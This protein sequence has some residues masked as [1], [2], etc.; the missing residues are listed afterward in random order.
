MPRLVLLCCL[1]FAAC[2]NPN[3]RTL[4]VHGA[5][6]TTAMPE[7]LAV[8]AEGLDAQGKVVA[9]A[10]GM[11]GCS[12]GTMTI[13]APLPKDHQVRMRFGVDADI[14][15]T[16]AGQ[17]TAVELRRLP[18][19]AGAMVD[20]TLELRNATTEASMTMSASKHYTVSLRDGHFDIVVK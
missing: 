3:E 2:A 5:T 18:G 11:L 4:V 6:V 16:L 7:S 13:G 1:P 8:L 20:G 15:V 10:Y 14:C 17:T 9:T 19:L 12:A